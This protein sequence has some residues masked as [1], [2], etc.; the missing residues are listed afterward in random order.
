[1]TGPG[2]LI[3]DWLFNDHLPSAADS[4]YPKTTEVN[5]LESINSKGTTGS[6]GAS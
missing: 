4:P 2:V 1:L 3:W 6:V 5:L